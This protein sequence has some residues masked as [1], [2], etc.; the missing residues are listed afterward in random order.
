MLSHLAFS[1]LCHRVK[2]YNMSIM[3]YDGRNRLLVCCRIREQENPVICYDIQIYRVME[4]FILTAVIR[5]KK[6][7]DNNKI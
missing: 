4:L 2:K 7:S 1:I 5:E 3:D 6:M